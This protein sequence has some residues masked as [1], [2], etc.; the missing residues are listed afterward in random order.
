MLNSRQRAQLRAMAN[1][2]ETIL[3]V[4]KGGI[5]ENTVK[6]VRDALEA[7]ELIKL[8]VLETSPTNSRETADQLAEEVECD[9]V[10]VIGTRFILYKESK[11]NKTIKLVK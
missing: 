3:Q 10:Q 5:N 1:D 11:N 9:V 6:Q 2:M 4:G 7:R 8:R